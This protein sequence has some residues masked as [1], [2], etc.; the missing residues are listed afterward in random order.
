MP[1]VAFDGENVR[2]NLPMMRI[3][4]I[5]V[6]LNAEK[7]KKSPHLVIDEK[8]KKILVDQLLFGLKNGGF[9]FIYM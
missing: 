4:T 7:R 8:I 3:Q 9:F 2:N 1:P 5:A 6:R